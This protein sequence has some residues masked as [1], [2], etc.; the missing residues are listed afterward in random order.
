MQVAIELNISQPALSKAIKNIEQEFDT[1]LFNRTANRI[2]LNEGGK[3]VL[4]HFNSILKEYDSISE[5]LQTMCQKNIKIGFCDSG[6]YWY[7]LPLLQQAFPNSNFIDSMYENINECDA[8]IK[9]NYDLLITPYQLNNPW[10]TSHY[11]LHDQIYLSV[12]KDDVLTQNKSISLKELPNR[13]LTDGQVNGYI[14]PIIHKILSP[15]I[16]IL[17]SDLM[18]S[19]QLV[20]TTDYLSIT[21]DIACKLRND[22]PYRQLIPINDKE[23]D[24]TYHLCYLKKNE[25]LYSPIIDFLSSKF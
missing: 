16:Q 8:L 2:E 22:G 6:I 18:L 5:S 9:Q 21:S 14:N 3:I 7:A 1:V 17:K 25:E 23:L 4:Q 15:N 24:I 19:L 10:I 13:I 20:Q 12:K 11:L